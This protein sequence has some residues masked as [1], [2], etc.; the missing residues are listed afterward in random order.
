MCFSAA[1]SFAAAALT[2]A[3]G[4]ATLRTAGAR[5][6]IPLAAFPLLFASQQIVEGL[7]WLRLAEGS[8]DGGAQVLGAVFMFYAEVLWPVLTPLAL[9]LVE[10]ESRRRWIVAGLLVAGLAL[11]GYFLQ[12]MIAAPFEPAIRGGSIVY[13]HDAP[14]VPGIEGLYVLVTCGPLLL[15]SHPA[16]K[17]LGAVLI[18]AF[19]VA[20]LFYF[21]ALISVWCFFA[22]LASGIV[23][24]HFARALRFARPS[25]S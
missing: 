9:W 25:G 3:I 16:L 5:R 24:L 14:H 13:W 2:G 21:V 11:A 4:I 19:L 6:D 8:A 17:L 20:A 10:P 7:L 18:L 12:A 22:A 15:S 23:Y 1:A